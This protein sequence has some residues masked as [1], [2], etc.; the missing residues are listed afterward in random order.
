VWWI[1]FFY[2]RYFAFGGC[3]IDDLTV[4]FD[5]CYLEIWESVCAKNALARSTFSLARWLANLYY[6]HL[7]IARRTSPMTLY[8]LI[9]D[10]L[11]YLTHEYTFGSTSHSL[12]RGNAR[13]RKSCPPTFMR[14]RVPPIPLHPSIPQHFTAITRANDS[15]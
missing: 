10:Q 8:L 6:A 9:R 1:F 7:P 2:F 4:C 15:K 13:I 14:S 5:S 3:P 11:T 12:S